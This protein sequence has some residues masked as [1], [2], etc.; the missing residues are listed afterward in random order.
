MVSKKAGA[1]AFEFSLL[2]IISRIFV[3]H[4]YPID[5][6]AGFLF[7]AGMAVIAVTIW[8][9]RQYTNRHWKTDAK[10]FP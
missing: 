8:K 7:G 3:G 9:Q 10:H 2:V 1:A 6:M 5:I 4:H